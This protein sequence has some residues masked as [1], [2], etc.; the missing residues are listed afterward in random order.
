M[1]LY[2]IDLILINIKLEI[3]HLYKTTIRMNIRLVIEPL[4]PIA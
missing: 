1:R 2:Y 3:I 4:T